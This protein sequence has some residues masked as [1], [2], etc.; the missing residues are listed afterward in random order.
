MGMWKRHISS[1]YTPVISDLRAAAVH[2]CACSRDKK[3]SYIFES[4]I[5]A[6][7]Q[8]LLRAGLWPASD[9]VTN[10]WKRR[11]MF[12]FIHDLRLKLS[13]SALYIC[14]VYDL[15][16][17][18]TCWCHVGF[19]AALPSFNIAL[20]FMAAWSRGGGSQGSLIS[21]NWNNVLL[22]S[23][24]GNPG[25]DWVCCLSFYPLRC[26]SIPSREKQWLGMQS[27][28]CVS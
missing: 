25:S 24:G 4:S 22:E 18:V 16:P 12:I 27:G 21:K 1:S 28:F 9:T 2:K 10:S 19:S 3:K 15:Y 20:R 13:S 26:L 11:L 23:S 7:S 6:F 8:H 17:P 14:P 5:S